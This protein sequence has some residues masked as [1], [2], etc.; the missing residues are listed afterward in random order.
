MAYTKTRSHSFPSSRD[1]EQSPDSPTQ[2]RRAKSVPISPRK[3]TNSIP[4]GRGGTT[5]ASN[6]AKSPVPVSKKGPKAPA[7][8]TLFEPRA[9][10]GDEDLPEPNE[11][12]GRIPI[13]GPEGPI[14][15]P[16]Q[17]SARG[18][19]GQ[20]IPALW[21]DR[22]HR[23]Q[24][25]SRFVKS[26]QPAKSKKDDEDDI[27]W[28]GPLLDQEEN[29]ELQLIDMR[30]R[31]W[32]TDT[33]PRRQPTYYQWERGAP[34]DWSN[35]QAI[36]ALNDRQKQAIDRITLDRSWTAEEL[37]V[38]SAIFRIY[39]NASI[40]EATERFNWHFAGEGGAARDAGIEPRTIESVR[41]EY[42]FNQDLY[43]NG[44]TPKVVKGR[45]RQVKKEAEHGDED[46]STEKP[47]KK[48][49]EASK[50]KAEEGKPG[51][52]AKAKGKRKAAE[53]VEDGDDPTEKP[54]KKKRVSQKKTAETKPA[55]SEKAK[56]KRKAV[57][58]DED[59]E[60][61]EPQSSRKK[62]NIGVKSGKQST[63]STTKSSAS[64]APS[65]TQKGTS[66]NRPLWEHPTFTNPELFQTGNLVDNLAA[67]GETLGPKRHKWAN[68]L[69]EADDEE[70]ARLQRERDEIDARI[71]RRRSEI[72]QSGILQGRRT[73]SQSAKARSR[74]RSQSA[75]ARS[76][77]RSR[78]VRSYVEP[79]ATHRDVDEHYSDI[80]DE[81]LLALT[82]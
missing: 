36:K 66:R 2:T 71:A 29:L 28:Q 6:E 18:S 76:R 78:S 7:V 58:I 22:K 53:V 26:F 79:A 45:G 23:F 17:P 67:L 24:I 65:H 48:K 43:D 20:T 82:Y 46:S 37:D 14:A 25:G 77:S 68:I 47:A 72:S 63:K 52:S 54:A 3:R 41:A 30:P 57:E 44:K 75:K 32:K 59:E 1:K 21:E 49:K 19:M 16:D 55:L 5:S 62:R 70:I 39:P 73:R 13:P 35:K 11:A 12:W 81:E 80:D 33:H 61:D 74:S 34:A 42:L 9:T 27:N 64:A 31:K 40:L 10:R 38:L 69:D 51:P 8:A 60:Q 4:Y 50:V 15:H 56:G